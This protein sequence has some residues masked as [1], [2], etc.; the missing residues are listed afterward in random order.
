MN[1]ESQTVLNAFQEIKSGTASVFH[2]KQRLN[3]GQLSRDSTS[4]ETSSHSQQTSATNSNSDNMVTDYDTLRAIAEVERSEKVLQQQQQQFQQ[5]QQQQHQQQQQQR[6]PHPAAVGIRPVVIPPPY[7]YPQQA[8]QPPSPPNLQQSVPTRP[9]PLPTSPSTTKR[10]GAMVKVD[11]T[12]SRK[13]SLEDACIT[14]QEADPFAPESIDALFSNPSTGS[15]HNRATSKV[16]PTAHA[17]AARAPFQPTVLP[18]HPTIPAKALNHTDSD[19]A[20]IEGSIINA[21][22]D[23]FSPEALD[24]LLKPSKPLP[25]AP[26]EYMQQQQHATYHGH[27][28]HPQYMQQQKRYPMQPIRGYEQQVPYQ[29]PPQQA[30]QMHQTAHYVP[31]GPRMAQQM[32]NADA[33]SSPQAQ[34]PGIQQQSQPIPPYHTPNQMMMH[35]G[36]T[37]YGQQPNYNGLPPHPA[38]YMSVPPA[39]QQHSATTTPSTKVDPFSPQALDAMLGLGPSAA[40]QHHHASSGNPSREHSREQPAGRMNPHQQQPPQL[41]STTANARDPFSPEALDALFVTNS[42]KPAHNAQQQ[43]NHHTNNPHNQHVNN[44]LSTSPSQQYSTRPTSQPMSIPIQ[45]PQYYQQQQQQYAVNAG[46]SLISRNR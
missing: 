12:N 16:S 38:H 7:P 14:V 24:A 18:P 2:M 17:S 31:G 32:M 5:L 41:Q 19:M 34:R 28:Q 25:V 13:D 46:K 30:Q 36:T 6:P 37:P 8:H 15:P 4:R 35:P 44:N 23:P 21:G 39:H 11:S 3:V 29:P 42:A 10:K 22:D 9:A 45:T 1:D 27:Q 20:S 26:P 33:R 43:H 40:Q